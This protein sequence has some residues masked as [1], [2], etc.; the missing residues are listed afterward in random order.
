VSWF[1]KLLKQRFT[2]WYNRR[3][4]RRGTLWEERFKSVLVEGQGRALAVMAAYID[5]NPVRAGMV[6][7]PGEY[8]WS[9]YAEAVAGR[10]LAREGLRIAV[11]AA[12]GEEVVPQRVLAKYRCHLFNEGEESEGHVTE[13]GVKKRRGFRREKVE[14]IIAAGGKL[15][16]W[17]LLRCRVRYFADGLLFGSQAFVERHFLEQRW[18]FSPK[19]QSGARKL[20]HVDLAELYTARDLRVRTI[21]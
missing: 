9:G 14:E 15:S 19:R 13:A 6:D 20:R 2:Q 5:L 1:M 3:A 10:K 16:S 17:E 8:R 7:D 4:Q 18:R 11:I 21:A 12:A